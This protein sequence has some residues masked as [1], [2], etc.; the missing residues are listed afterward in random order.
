MKP[1]ISKLI[2]WLPIGFTALFF[3]QIFGLIPFYTHSRH[4]YLQ[5]YILLGWILSY[6][7][8]YAYS[9]KSNNDSFKKNPLLKWYVVLP[10]LFILGMFTLASLNS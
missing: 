10:V 8:A 9:F 4:S 6:V 5:T 1:F 3:L 7:V 2:L